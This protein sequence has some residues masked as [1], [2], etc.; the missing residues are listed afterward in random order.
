MRLVKNLLMV[1]GVLVLFALFAI[2]FTS[3]FTR[4][5]QSVEVPSFVGVDSEKAREIADDNNLTS[6]ISDS[7]YSEQ[8]RKFAIVEQDPVAGSKVKPGRNIYMIINS[9]IK[10][11]VKMPKL[12][13]GSGNLAK[14]LLQNLGLKLGRVDS[15]RVVWN[16]GYVL[17]QYY[18]G[19]EIAPNTGVEKGAV[20]DLLVTKKTSALDTLGILQDQIRYKLD[21]KDFD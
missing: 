19:R 8:V 3:W 9:G 11:K 17:K 6:V 10:P 18:K 16:S 4:H 1:A 5:G 12:V 13:E 20:I 15:A 21:P 7:V 2:W 14:V